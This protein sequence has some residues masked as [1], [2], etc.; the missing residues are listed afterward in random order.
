MSQHVSIYQ[1]KTSGLFPV[2]GVCDYEKSY[3]NTDVYAFVWYKFS[4]LLDR[5]LSVP[6]AELC[7]FPRPPA[8][9]HVKTLT[10]N[11]TVLSDK[12]FIR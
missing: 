9:V 6:W 11:V 7:P 5:Y 3:Y 10:P 8:Q 12:A 1:L 4:L 2:F